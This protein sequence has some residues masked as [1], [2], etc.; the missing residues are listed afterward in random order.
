MATIG[1]RRTQLHNQ[2]RCTPYML[3]SSTQ[4]QHCL[5]VQCCV[6]FCW[7]KHLSGQH[8]V[9]IKI[10]PK[11]HYKCKHNYCPI[12]HNKITV[13]CVLKYIVHYLIDDLILKSLYLPKNIR[14]F[15][16]RL[17]FDRQADWQSHHCFRLNLRNLSCFSYQSFDTIPLV[18]F[19]LL[20]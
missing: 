4:Q 10:T 12:V 9:L 5:A 14:W 16:R 20:P 3:N 17:E 6:I 15:A 7:F 13:Q 1:Q 18:T 11:I 19:L 2:Q 8:I